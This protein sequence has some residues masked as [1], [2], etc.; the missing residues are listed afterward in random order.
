VTSVTHGDVNNPLSAA[1]RRRRPG[2][3]G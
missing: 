2:V 1:Q 3:G